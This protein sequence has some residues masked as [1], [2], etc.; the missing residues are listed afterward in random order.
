MLVVNLFFVAGREFQKYL[1]KRCDSLPV[2][3][4]EGLLE[5]RLLGNDWKLVQVDGIFGNAVGVGARVDFPL[6]LVIIALPV[7]RSYGDVK[8]M[9][10]IMRRTQ[11]ASL[12]KKGSFQ[13]H[14][15]QMTTEKR[16][17]DLDCLLVVG[18]HVFCVGTVYSGEFLPGL[19][20]I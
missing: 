4:L 20:V 11:S 7:D 14:D 8:G 12:F 3:C 1:T 18:W 5:A 6:E 16:T 17:A 19:F 15:S 9:V 2:A 10:L 13:C